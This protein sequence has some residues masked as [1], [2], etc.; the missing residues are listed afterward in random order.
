V[1]ADEEVWLPLR[2]SAE[3]MAST[4]F[5]ICQFQ[6]VLVTTN[7]AFETVKSTNV[8]KVRDDDTVWTTDLAWT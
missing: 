1:T 5:L 2:V 8:S 7:T 6:G 3:A 4:D